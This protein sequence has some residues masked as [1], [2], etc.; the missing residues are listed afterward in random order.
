MRYTSCVAV[1]HDFDI[2]VRGNNDDAVGHVVQNIIEFFVVL[3]N[4]RYRVGKFF[5]DIVDFRQHF[6][7]FGVFFGRRGRRKR[8]VVQRDKVVFYFSHRLHKAFRQHDA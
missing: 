1:V 8:A 7:D 4:R 2:S 3:G 6:V 5:A